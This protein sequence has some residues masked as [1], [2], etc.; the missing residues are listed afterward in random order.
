MGQIVF[1]RDGNILDGIDA[2][3]ALEQFGTVSEAAVRLRLTQ[4]AVTKRIQVLQRLLGYRLIEP[5]GRRVRLTHAA[6]DYLQRARPLAA[7]LR[8]L[9]GVARDGESAEF[10]LALADSIASSWG[11]GV[12][13]QALQ[14]VPR[15]TLRLHAHRSVLLIENVRLGR[16][17]IG[18]ST[19][20]PAAR[21]LLHFP[22]I[23][24]P[25]V[26]VNADLGHRARARQPLITIEPS[27][28]TW[29]AIEP[30][31]RAAAPRLLAAPL[32]PVETF[33]AAVQMAKA[34]FGDGLVPL[35]LA[36][37]LRLDQRCYRSLAGVQ[38]RIALVTRKTL[39]QHAG[40]KRLHQSLA[41]QARSYFARAPA[42]RSNVPR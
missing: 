13:K 9:S 35:G 17:H 4:S 22:L 28:A 11:P 12:I 5:E 24:E 18:L 20:L 23:D 16:Y 15:I 7:D 10:S 41:E 21:D 6:I 30:Q 36:L 31:I 42:G 33:S 2:L 32:V 14:R 8:A 26:L 1:S 29:Q 25:M 3:T 40:F 38:R 39:S 27:A 19:D 34:G 37:A